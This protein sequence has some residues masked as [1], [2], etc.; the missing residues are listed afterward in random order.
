[1]QA[2]R[3]GAFGLSR[4]RGL[5]D[6]ICPACLYW[7]L[8]HFARYLKTLITAVGCG[9]GTEALLAGGAMLAGIGPPGIGSLLRIMIMA[10]HLP[11]FWLI[12]RFHVHD[13]TEAFGL[14]M[15]LYAAVWSALWYLFWRARFTRKERVPDDVV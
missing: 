11:G 13:G 10:M 12:R 5:A 8:D 1:M 4:S 7:S 2:T 9:I 14:V 3:D 15:L 6:V